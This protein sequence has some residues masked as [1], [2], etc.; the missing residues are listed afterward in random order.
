MKRFRVG[1]GLRAELLQS[2]AIGVAMRMFSLGAGLAI[3]VVLART[4]APAGYG[5]YSF[6][7]SLVSLLAVPVQLGLPTL[8]LR[9]VSLSFEH[10]DFGKLRSF[11]Q[12]SHRTILWM[13]AL[14]A[15]ATVV[16]I[17]MLR[18]HLEAQTVATVLI[19]ISLLALA[20]M[21]RLR[22]ATLQGLRQFVLAQIPD[23][24]VL[25]TLFIGCLA[26]AR[27][28]FPQ[29]LQPQ[30]A[31]LAYVICALAVLILGTIFLSR[32][33]PT[34][35]ARA[36]AVFQTRSWARSL[37]PLALTSGFLLINGHFSILILGLLSSSEDAGL[38]RVAS[39]GAA[40]AT[41]VGG[42]I[43]S[44]TSPH[45]ATLY[46]RGDVRRLQSLVN[47]SAWASLI[48]ALL[49]LCVFVLI[50]GPLLRH[51]Y[52]A[53]FEA[54]RT[55]LIILTVG[56]TVNSATGVVHCLLNMTG[57]ERDTLNGV[58]LGAATNVALSAAL[59]PAFGL[60][61]AA[62]A[63]GTAIAVENLLLCAL[64]RTRL[65]IGSTIFSRAWS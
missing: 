7:F 53:P 11:L 50:G 48:P 60:T 1:G 55:T 23:L 16:V 19:A 52:G 57:H 51:I 21:S 38:F 25:P 5:V 35:T 32:R 39:S 34:E 24:V 46:S 36:T 33:L 14:M 26:A 56:Q 12:W 28:W 59:V 30:Y 3:T 15:V 41:F 45:I 54:A 42:S 22:E 47:Y 27:L 37:L 63:T 31:M 58:V 62:I 2:G 65:N 4:L 10:R 64:V 17:W 20:P 29:T 49:V 18:A 43:G 44:L 13:S 6:A 40:L 9:E 8:A 61:G